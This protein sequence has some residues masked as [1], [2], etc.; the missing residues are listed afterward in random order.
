MWS[1]DRVVPLSQSSVFCM[2]SGLVFLMGV[3][4]DH[5]LIWAPVHSDKFIGVII[6]PPFRSKLFTS[7]SSGQCHTVVVESMPTTV[8][9]PQS[10]WHQMLLVRQFSL[11]KAGQTNHC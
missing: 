8:L 4:Y 3:Y 5:M 10:K 11:G 1:G 6:F 9:C 7:L 2:L